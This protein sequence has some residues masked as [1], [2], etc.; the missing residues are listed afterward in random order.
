[1]KD[2]NTDLYAWMDQIIAANTNSSMTSFEKMDAVCEYLTSEDRFSYHTMSN[3]ETV[4]LASIPNG[5]C[6]LSHRWNSYVSPYYA[7]C[8]CRK[9][10]GL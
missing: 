8:V 10:R 6:F 4:T 2:Y 1:M 7:L 9:D 5:P 3:G